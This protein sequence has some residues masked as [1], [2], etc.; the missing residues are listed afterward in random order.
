MEDKKREIRRDILLASYG[1]KACHIGSALSCVDILVD[2]LY[3]IPET[4]VFLFGKASGVLTYYAIL[5]DQ[6]KF[7]KDKLVEYIKNYPLPSKEVPGV[8]HSMGSVGHALSV[9]EGIALGD[10]SKTVHV[11]LSDGDCMEG[12][13]YE[14]VLFARQHKLTNLH[15]IVDDNGLVACGKT[16]DILDLEMAYNF[17]QLSLP[18]FERV[19]TI[20]GKGVSFMENNHHWHYKNLSHEDLERALW[21]I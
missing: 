17:M 21:E 13:T 1:A 2:L 4:D 16:K 7:P 14:A 6:G 9:A 15:V 8:I 11:L 10:R 12:S 3:S 5:A 19:E 18:W 20:K